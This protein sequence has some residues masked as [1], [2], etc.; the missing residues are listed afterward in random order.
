[1]KIH[2]SIINKKL[3]LRLIRPQPT[4][5]DYTLHPDSLEII[6]KFKYPTQETYT[7]FLEYSYIVIDW[8][9]NK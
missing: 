8:H 9:K 1:M 7:Y 5:L 4:H 2:V 3:N 6:L